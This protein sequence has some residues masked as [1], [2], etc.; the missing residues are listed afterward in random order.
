MPYLPLALLITEFYLSTGRAIWLALL[1]GCLG[2]QWTL[3]H[4]QIQTWTG[5]LVLVTALGRV[6]LDRM[7]WLRAFAVLVA[8]AW[9]A[10]LASVQLGPSWYLA[11]TVRQIARPPAE[12]M[13]YSFPPAHWF[14][15]VLPWLI[16]A[17]SL[18]PEDPY[19]FGQQTWGYEA[20]FYV[21]T[22]PLVFAFVGALGR[23][24]SRSAGMWRILL[25]LGFALATM[26]RWW[27]QGYLRLLDVPGIG[28]F[29]SP[30]RYTLFSCF[31]L[32]IL[33]GEGFERSI[34]TLRFRAG[35]AAALVF[36]ACATAA[37]LLWTSRTNVHLRPV[38][39]DP[40]GGFLWAAASWLAALAVVLAW[41][42]WRLPAWVPVIVTGLELALLLF[43][44]ATR[45]ASAVELPSQSPAIKEL[46]ARSP[47]GLVGGEIE[48]V[49]VRVGLPTAYPYLG[50]GQLGPN[51]ALILSQL[52]PLYLDNSSTT[53]EF[54]AT[55]ARLWLRR[56]RVEYLI[57]SHRSLASFGQEVARC[58]DPVLDQLVHRDLTD[59]PRRIW[60]IIKL[61]DPVPEARVALRAETVADHAD[62]VGRLCVRDE[63]DLAMFLAEDRVPARANTR[64]AQVESW[65][66]TTAK[67][68]HSGT[69]DLVIARAFD[70]GWRAQIDDGPEQRVLPVNDGFQA[71]RVEGSGTH[72]IRL[73]Y[74]PPWFMLYLVISLIALAAIAGIIIAALVTLIKGRMVSRRAASILGGT[75]ISKEVGRTCD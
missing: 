50:F 46:L 36:A 69:C 19:W 14:E 58:E 4:F 41:R 72:L 35:A 25:P 10:A 7:S 1:A 30:A 68:K 11:A 21:G 55:M 5:T 20:A 26:P 64:S 40:T 2:I 53:S 62:L 67:V 28:Y 6:S 52:R 15:P 65:D 43:N 51:K 49:P 71:V 63:P 8:V 75:R 9:G 61:D 42:A 24:A 57:S 13:F 70:A 66:G 22:I 47:T 38:G 56:C 12:L 27:P 60:S 33:A 45:W 18:G 74:A 73:W 31:G 17:I 44:G 32:A 59:P 39:G 37:A 29:R 23:P 3:G 16:R 48:N 54:K 34:S